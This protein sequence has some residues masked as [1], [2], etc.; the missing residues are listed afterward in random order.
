MIAYEDAL[1]TVLDEVP[2]LD[3][4]EAGIEEVP[5]RVLAEGVFSDTDLPPFDKSAMDGFAVTESALARIPCILRVRETVLAGGA[6]PGPVDGGECVKVMTG[7][8]VPEG[9][10][11]VVPVEETES[12][13]EGAVRVKRAPGASNICVQGEDIH[14]GGKVLGAGTILAEEHVGLLAA[15]GRTRVSV[16]RRPRAALVVTGDEVVPHSETPPPGKI[17]DANS[18]MLVSHLRRMGLEVAFL[19]RVRDSRE[20][21]REHLSR[22]LEYDVLVTTGAVSMG[23]T[24]FL[25]SVLREL[26]A[27]VLFDRVAQ[28]PGKPTTFARRGSCAVFALPGN[29]VTA[30]VIF[31]MLVRPGLLAMMG[32]KAPGPGLVRARVKE[33]YRRKKS[34]RLYFAPAELGP[35]GVKVL[36]SRGSA[37]LVTQARANSLALVRV[38]VKTLAPG[39]EVETYPY[40]QGII[41]R[42]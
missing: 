1:R 4:E 38:G 2:R 35:D 27:H 25:A 10:T 37:D 5:A 30:S 6:L 28:K 22:G 7:G 33:S 20:L 24:D 32:A 13:G 36:A 18:P 3:A 8:V 12:A 19:G 40:G 16:S 31:R 11:A 42:R 9:A 14:S 23:E 21:F 41:D 26:G 17:R 39:D 29:P 34:S 15:V